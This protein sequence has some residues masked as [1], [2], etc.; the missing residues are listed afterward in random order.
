[1]PRKNCLVEYN[2]IIN[3]LNGNKYL[4]D[5]TGKWIIFKNPSFEVHAKIKKTKK[6]KQN[7]IK[8]VAFKLFGLKIELVSKRYFLINGKKVIKLHGRKI[9]RFK[10]G[11]TIKKRHNVFTFTA[12]HNKAVVTITKGKLSL[13]IIG[14]SKEGLCNGEHSMIKSHDLLSKFKRCKHHHHHKTCRKQNNGK[15][16]C[17]FKLCDGKGKFSKFSFHI[18][19]NK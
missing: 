11:G 16:K 14:N 2:G 6:T 19:R 18:L 13:N 4:Q 9:H 10:N 1:M 8:K 15:V 12:G 5:F 3:S 17:F 7:R